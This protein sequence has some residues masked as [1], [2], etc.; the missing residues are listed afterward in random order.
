MRDWRRFRPTTPAKGVFEPRAAAGAAS[1]P[2]GPLDTLPEVRLETGPL[3]QGKSVLINQLLNEKR[4]PD[5]VWVKRAGMA[6]YAA[7]PL[8]LEDQFVGLMVIFAQNPLTEQISRGMGSV[9]NPDS[10]SSLRV[11][12]ARR[13]WEEISARATPHFSPSHIFR[14]NSL[15]QCVSVW[16][17]PRNRRTPW[18]WAETAGIAGPFD[19][20]RV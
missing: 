7:Y 19:P 8:V 11:G 20:A 2:N 12:T 9:A 10:K 1:E 6:A 5:Q 14:R 16:T 4:I 15:K 18:F 3:A 17:P 13:S